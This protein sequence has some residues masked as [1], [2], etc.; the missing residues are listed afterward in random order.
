MRHREVR[1]LSQGHTASQQQSWSQYSQSSEAQ[2]GTMFWT[3]TDT[4]SLSL[5]SSEQAHPLYLSSVF[6]QI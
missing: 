3:L 6:F 5:A 1:L 4:L 2:E